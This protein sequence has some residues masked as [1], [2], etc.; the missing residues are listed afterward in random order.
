MK[1]FA[2]TTAAVLLGLAQL[3]AA[4]DPTRDK[5]PATPCCDTATSC[6]ADKAK[7]KP[8]APMCSKS[9]K[10]VCCGEK[11]WLDIETVTLEAA[12]GDPIAQYTIAY[13]T[14]V[15]DESTAPDTGKAMEWYGKSVDGLKK[16]ADE[17]SATACCALARMYSEGKGVEKDPAMAEKYMKMCKEICNKKAE[18]CKDKK[19]DT[20]AAPAQN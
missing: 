10:G 4:E 18:K 13:L 11:E 17:G 5:T 14:E 7:C 19:A 15:G 16:A 1:K 8:C 2:I 12:N 20:P 9:D 6:C 3:T